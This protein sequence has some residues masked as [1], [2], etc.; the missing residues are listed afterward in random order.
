MFVSGTNW[1]DFNPF[2]NSD[3]VPRLLSKSKPGKKRKP[4]NQLTFDMIYK[5][6]GEAGFECLQVATDISRYTTLRQ[7]DICA[8]RW[9]KH[10]ADGC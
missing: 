10:I 8:M 7:R 2:T 6:A 4:C 1:L 9:D 3:D 5:N